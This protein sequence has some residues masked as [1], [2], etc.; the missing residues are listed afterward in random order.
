[1]PDKLK[2]VRETHDTVDSKRV[3]SPQTGTIFS[4][5]K[6]ATKIYLREYYV[7]LPDFKARCKKEKKKYY[8]VLVTHF[9]VYI[10]HNKWLLIERNT[11]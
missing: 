10:L 1:M 8:Y 9:Q 11:R 7:I 3:L 4:S 6:I 5:L 2:D